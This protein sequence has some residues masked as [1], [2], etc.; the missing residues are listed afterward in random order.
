MKKFSVILLMAVAAIIGT[1]T[2]S[3]GGEDPVAPK[4]STT[5]TTETAVEANNKVRVGLKDYSIVEEAARTNSTYISGEDKTAIIVF[6][7]DNTHGDIDFQITFKGKSTGTYT[8]SEVGDNGLV[9]GL[10]TGT[11][12]DVRRQEHEASTTTLTVIVT[13]YGEVGEQVKGTFSGQVKNVNGQTVNIS[14]GEFEVTRKEDT[15]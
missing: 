7:S 15:M 1:T 3:C 13:E 6:G 2:T 8:S 4:V 5:D 14:N 10:G 12:G 9:F 11:E